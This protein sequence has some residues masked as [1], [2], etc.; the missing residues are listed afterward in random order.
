MDHFQHG[1][2]ND[3][4]TM[5]LVW[6]STRALSISNPDQSQEVKDHYK[7]ILEKL[8]R[9]GHGRFAK[10]LNPTEIGYLLHYA[11][12]WPGCAWQLNQDPSTH[13]MHS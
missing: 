1:I 5:E 12:N 9:A 7:I 6:A 11:P 2:F 8:G 3:E 13:S 10:A 4:L